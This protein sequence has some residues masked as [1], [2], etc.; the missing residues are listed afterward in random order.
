[1]RQ[2]AHPSADPS[3]G[4]RVRYPA[5]RSRP[6]GTFVLPLT[7]LLGS[8]GCSTRAIRLRRRNDASIPCGR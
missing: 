1:M 5:T 3:A 7:P 2:T 6:R 4:W 8:A